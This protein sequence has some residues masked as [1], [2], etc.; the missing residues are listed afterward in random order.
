MCLVMLFCNQERPRKD[1]L[2]SPMILNFTFPHNDSGFILCN[3]DSPPF[4]ETEG[5]LPGS[6][7]PANE[8]YS[9][10]DN[11]SLQLHTLVLLVAY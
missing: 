4:V 3:L 8:P 10:S 1:S 11:P 6:L 5:S 2:S 9:E 7:E